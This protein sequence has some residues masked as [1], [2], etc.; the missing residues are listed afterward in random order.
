M[1][2]S[3]KV[4]DHAENPRNVGTLDK[5]DPNVGTGLVGAPACFTG[6]TLVALAD[7]RKYARL[8]ELA[9]VGNELVLYGYNNDEGIRIRRASSVRLTRTNAKIV[10]VTLDD[11]SSFRCTPDHQLLKRNKAWATTDE[12]KPGES[13]MP[14]NRIVRRGYYSIYGN[15]QDSRCNRPAEHKLIYEFFHG[16]VVNG[17]QVH[18][19][20][21]SKLD[22]RPENLEQL[23]SA[24]HLRHHNVIKMHGEAYNHRVISIEPAGVADVYCVSVEHDGCFAIV[25]R[26]D[27][28]RHTGIIVHNCGDVMR[29]QIKVNDQGVIEDA[30]FKTFGCLVSNAPI[31]T[32]QGYQAISDLKPGDEVWAWN[33][34]V[35]RNKVKSIKTC[36]VHWTRLLRFQFEQARAVYC[37]D[38]HVWWTADNRPICASDL[39][40]N[41]ELLCMT[42]NELRSINNV[43]QRSEFRLQA[44]QRTHEFNKVLNHNLLPQNTIGFKKSEKSK[45]R[46]SIASKQMWQDPEYVQK[47]QRG[48]ENALSTRPTQL[49]HKFIER[50]E[51]AALDVRYVGNG[52]F[53]V[54]TPSGERLN[55]DFKVNGQRKLIEVYTSKMPLHMENRDTPDWMVRKKIAYASAGFDSMFIDVSELENSVPNVQRFIH[56]GVRVTSARR[57]SDKRSL[58][59]LKRNGN[60][61]VVYDLELE[62]GANIFFVQRA[63]SH[64]CGSAI[65]S[66][67]LATEWIKGKS[68]DEAEA[69]KNTQIVEELNLPPVKI[70]CSVLAEDAIKSAIADYRAKQAALAG[71]A[72]K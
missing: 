27:S 45:H 10:K 6:D 42:E 58:K 55:P 41:Q 59:G 72:R 38:D 52:E 30:K 71:L 67:S 2:Y 50:F 4:L 53:W 43:R 3:E 66:S 19:K 5:D 70:H 9:A 65:A 31:A 56:N 36:R 51:Y 20:N 49:E 29:L 54:N 21:H 48:M 47:R 17:N 12:I 32:P 7:G 62:E 64:N 23:T 11:G 15:L 24:E 46:S 1:A 22:N 33:G 44:K 69:I 14:F 39:S 68:L 40:I 25:T 60:E 37:T 18:H 26:V 8:D 28:M 57:L 16:P 13:L 63:M 61:V 34:Q 35:V